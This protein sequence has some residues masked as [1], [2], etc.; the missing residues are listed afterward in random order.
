MIRNPILCLNQ[1]IPKYQNEV[2]EAYFECEIIVNAIKIICFAAV[3]VQ[4]KGMKFS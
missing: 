2:S 3:A 1:I 4:C